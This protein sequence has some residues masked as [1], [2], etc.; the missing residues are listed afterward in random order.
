MCFQRVVCSPAFDIAAAVCRIVAQSV[1]RDHTVVRTV[2]LDLVIFWKSDFVCCTSIF[3][4]KSNGNF[5]YGIFLLIWICGGIFF[6][7]GTDHKRQMIGVSYGCICVG[8]IFAAFPVTPDF[9]AGCA[10]KIFISINCIIYKIVGRWK[11]CESPWPFSCFRG[12]VCIQCQVCIGRCIVCICCHIC[13]TDRRFCLKYS[14]PSNCFSNCSVNF[15]DSRIPEICICKI[16]YNFLLLFFTV[17]VVYSYC[18]RHGR[19]CPFCCCHG[20]LL[21]TYYGSYSY[22]CCDACIGVNHGSARA[23][24]SDLF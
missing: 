1:C 21:H 20:Y 8:M 24:G 14:F 13:H 9:L 2:I 23:K 6:S 15:Y 5:I 4:H 17:A 11:I 16:P 19:C 7:E 12:T 3:F 18:F 10:V 22:F